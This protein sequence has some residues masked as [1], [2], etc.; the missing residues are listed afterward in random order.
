[1]EAKRRRDH[2]QGVGVVDAA[3]GVR[4]DVGIH[5]HAVIQAA[6]CVGDPAVAGRVHET[7]R[8]YAG[9]LIDARHA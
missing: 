5:G 3:P 6:N 1:M 4:N 8:H 7:A 2:L 9:N